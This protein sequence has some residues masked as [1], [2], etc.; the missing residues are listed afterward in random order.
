MPHA[1]IV[2]KMQPILKVSAIVY[3]LYKFERR[4]EIELTQSDI[5]KAKYKMQ[6]WSF[7]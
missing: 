1:L 2:L 5:Y 4:A 6:P 7:S 3:H